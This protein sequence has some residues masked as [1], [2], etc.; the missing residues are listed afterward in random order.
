MELI[1]NVNREPWGFEYKLVI[2]IPNA[3]QSLCSMKA[4]KMKEIVR[5]LFPVYPIGVNDER[6]STEQ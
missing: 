6:E 5:P 4:M 3:H 2:K 1:I